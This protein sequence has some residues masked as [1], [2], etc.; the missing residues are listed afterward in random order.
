MSKLKIA[1][2]IGSAKT[3]IYQVGGGV[4]L[5]EPSMVAVGTGAKGSVNFVGEE[6]KRMYGK[7]AKGTNVYLPV[8]EGEIAKVAP[9]KIM[10]SEF[11]KRIEAHRFGGVEA[12]VTLPC[13][14]ENPAVE[15]FK[16]LLS[17]CGI[18]G[19]RFI[20]SP[21]ATAV[22]LGATVNDSN[23]CFLIDMGGGTVNI[24]A[25]SLGGVIAGVS[26]NI[27]GSR[28]DNMLI[29]YIEDNYRLR[30]G[31]QTAERIKCEIGSLLPGDST[32][33]VV[34]G[35]DIDSGN[36]RAMQI[37]ASDIIEPIR[38]YVGKVYEFASMVMAKLPPEVS[39]EM[40]G[41]G[42]YLA[43][44]VSKLIGLE[45]FF[46]DEYSLSVRVHEDPELSTVIG[47]GKI[48]Q[49]EKLFKRL[50]FK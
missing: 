26:A 30:I 27:G 42:V 23:S 28:I 21:V 45:E 41:T 9:A 47:A 49:N 22:G 38:I 8:S 17:S 4:I 34:N 36:P 11:L 18:N 16:D 15:K 37:R 29:E 33:T 32:S 5:S 25:V 39:A 2:D 40:R 48:M 1:I 43:G 3:A 46:Y 50:T 20:E 6:A 7:S 31:A 14:T 12:L 35:R 24:A 44:G 13:G 19:A 10:L